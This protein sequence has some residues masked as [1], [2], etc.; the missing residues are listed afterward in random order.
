MST[1]SLINV[2][3]Q[4]KDLVLGYWVQDVIGSLEI[5]K[6]VAKETEIANDNKVNIVVVHKLN[7]TV[8][9]LSFYDNLKAK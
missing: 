2:V 7:T 4:D 6:K 8:P 9:D 1:Y 5:A 3:K